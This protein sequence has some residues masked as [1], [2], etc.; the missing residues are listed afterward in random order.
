MAKVRYTGYVE[1][2]GKVFTNQLVSGV[3]GNTKREVLKSLS[4]QVN[5]FLLPKWIAEHNL[6]YR[7]TDETTGEVT[8]L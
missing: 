4:T 2:D 3:S 7:I 1:V 6:K 5:S 8:V